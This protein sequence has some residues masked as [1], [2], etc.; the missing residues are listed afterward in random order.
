MLVDINDLPLPQVE[1]LPGGGLRIGALARDERRGAHARR[2]RALPGARRRRCCWAPR[3][4]CATWPRWAAT[5]CQR[6]RC[7]Y[8]RDGV[9]PCNKR[10]PGAGCAAL[11]GLNRG[12]AIL[13]TS[14]HCI[15]THP[16]D[17]AVALVALDAVV[18]TTA[19]GASGRSPI[20]DFYLLPG[21]TP[22][23]E[24][25]L[26]HGE[27]IVA[28]EVPPL[29][30]RP[31]V[32]LPEGPR[33][34]VVRVRVGVGRG[35]ARGRATGSSPGRG[36]RWAAWPPSRGGPAGPR[37]G[38]SAAPAD[39]GDVR[40]ARRAEELR[41][42]DAARAQ[43]FQGRAAQRAMVRALARHPRREAPH[44][45]AIGRPR[46]ARRR[47]REGHRCGALLGGDR[48]ARTSPTP[49]SSAPRSPAGGSSRSTP[50]RPSA[51][52]A[53]WPC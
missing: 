30:A 52:T 16:S 53:C 31:P 41:P 25:P 2:G 42:R 27:L 48:A 3:R 32:G 12:H 20:D 15:A 33:P 36:W 8:F 45:R 26:E 46:R 1:D 9:S 28:I 23:R 38:C 51:P 40:G 44:D 49:A 19:R 17:L 7:A 11:D 24:H 39:A 50:P 6:T 35:R 10:E 43:R 18:H 34:R 5:C 4:S 14:E 21:D 37:R 29:A 22:E 13:G 47:P